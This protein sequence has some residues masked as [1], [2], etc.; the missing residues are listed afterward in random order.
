MA[1]SLNRVMLVGNLTRDPQLSYL[2]SNTPV[3]DFSLAMNHRWKD[4]QGNQREEVCFVECK[5]FGKGG[6]VISKYMV[7]GRPLFVEGRLKQDQWTAQ[8]GS[9]RSKLYVVVDQFQFVGERRE[10]GPNQNGAPQAGAPQGGYQGGYQR[11]GPAGA[12]G[13][14]ASPPPPVESADPVDDHPAAVDEPPAMPDP[15]KVPF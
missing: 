5:C 8:D 11:R 4:Q 6:E 12:G 10:G 13:S 14:E 15:D 7:K 2:P 3:C 1:F 9:K